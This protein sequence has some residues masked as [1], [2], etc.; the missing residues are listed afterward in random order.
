MTMAP[1]A[2]NRSNSACHVVGDDVP[3][4]PT[5]MGIL[6]GDLG[7]GPTVMLPDPIIQPV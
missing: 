6:A 4:D 1:A 7:V 2:L 3:D 5:R